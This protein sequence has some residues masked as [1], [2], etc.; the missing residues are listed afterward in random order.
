MI[1]TL[2]EG[3]EMNNNKIN[4]EINI[5][6]IKGIGENKR[7]RERDNIYNNNFKI[8]Y[9]E[10]YEIKYKECVGSRGVVLVER[11]RDKMGNNMCIDVI[12]N[13][14][15]NGDY[16]ITYINIRSRRD[17]MDNNIDFLVSE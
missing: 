12:E 9:K 13:K 5:L 14:R 6:I 2:N 7:K 4:D 3:C 16:N 1:K 10:I 17:E 11:G 15:D 8:Y